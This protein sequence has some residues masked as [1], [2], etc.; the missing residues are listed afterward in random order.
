MG[1]SDI[2]RPSPSSYGSIF[3]E[4]T[5]SGARRKREFPLYSPPQLSGNNP[6]YLVRPAEC[7]EYELDLA[8][9]NIAV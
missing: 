4:I 1:D 3:K 6:P 9:K 2:S 5:T 7:H 8:V